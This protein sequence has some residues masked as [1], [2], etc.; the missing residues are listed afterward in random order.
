M[1][2]RINQ[3]R[4]HQTN[5]GLP[6]TSSLMKE[7]CTALT[8][9]F[10]DHNKVTLDLRGECG[11]V[12]WREAAVN[13][14]L[15]DF[16]SR[17]LQSPEALFKFRNQEEKGQV[18]SRC[19]SGTDP[20]S[21]SFLVFFSSF[22]FSIFQRACWSGPYV[23][24]YCLPFHVHTYQYCTVQYCT[25]QYKLYRKLTLS[26]RGTLGEVGGAWQPAFTACL[27]SL[28]SQP[29]RTIQYNAR[30]ATLTPMKNGAKTTLT[31]V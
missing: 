30:S 27:L 24:P 22:A 14:L 4:D 10:S 29:A 31:L 17:L 6:Q 5:G 19:S 1:R 18:W 26:L 23:V 20:P 13:A 25:V 16:L 21:Y 28:P 15:L 2:A 11:A 9:H 8:G 7:G 12:E 3:Q